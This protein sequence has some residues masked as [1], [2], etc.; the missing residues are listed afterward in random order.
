MSGEP[1]TSPVTPS[2]ESLPPVTSGVTASRYDEDAMASVYKVCDC[3]TPVKC[4]HA[5]WFSVSRRGLPRLRASLDVVLEQHLETK[6]EAQKAAD[7]LRDAIVAGT[8]T[9]RQRELLKLPAP[10]VPVLEQLTMRRLL[11]QYRERHV[12]T[13]AGADRVV[14]KLGAITR[15]PLARTDGVVEPFGDWLVADVTADTL[16]RLREARSVRTVH[17]T[18]RYRNVSG[19]AITANK[20]LR[21]LR[22][23]FNWAI[24]KGLVERSPF[25]RG[26]RTTVKVVQ[27]QA[28]SRRLLEGEAERLLPACNPFLRALVEAALETG[29]RLG[30]LLSLQVHQ[31]QFEPRAE[32]WLPAAKTKTGRA[33]RVPMSGRLR[34]VLDMRIALL[35]QTADL[36]PE[37]ELKP[38]LF[39]FGNAIGEAVKGIS[40]AWR[41]ACTRAEIADLHFHDL[42]REAGSRWMEGG[43]PLVTIQRWLGHTNIAQTST[44]LATTVHSEHDAMQRFEARRA[45][46]QIDTREGNGGERSTQ[47]AI[48]PNTEPQEITVKH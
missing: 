3:R 6:T 30:E 45:G 28:R 36:Q 15:T 14:Y 9:A 44:Y 16:D 25:K 8:V 5:W 47:N 2:L 26:D 19:G 37:D 10:A 31:V 18:G 1:V 29:C 27:E 35:R 43:V 42:R 4:K 46:H 7:A 34:A 22:A 39:V 13:L 41:V 38:D 11:D 48:R 21:I 20:D 23:A 17:H 24:D 33:R 40:R 12:R 32:I